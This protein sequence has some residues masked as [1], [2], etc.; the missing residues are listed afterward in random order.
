MELFFRRRGQASD[1]A[2][3]V[4]RCGI[5]FLDSINAVRAVT[6][7]EHIVIGLGFYAPDSTQSTAVPPLSVVTLL[8]KGPVRTMW[9]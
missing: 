4:S 3:S 9:R 2:V 5:M 8:A 1:I 7:L 6:G